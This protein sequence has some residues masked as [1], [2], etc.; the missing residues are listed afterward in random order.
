M[1]S[2]PNKLNSTLHQSA[3]SCM[4]LVMRGFLFT[5]TFLFAQFAVSE[6]LEGLAQT[7]SNQ[8]LFIVAQPSL[9]KIKCVGFTE[10]AA[11]ILKKISTDDYLIIQ[12][13]LQKNPNPA[14]SEPVFLVSNVLGVGLSDLIGGWRD[15]KQNLV[16][17]NFSQVFITETRANLSIPKENMQY[18]I[19][20]SEGGWMIFFTSQESIQIARLSIVADELELTFIEAESGNVSQSK[21]F[22]RIKP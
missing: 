6:T 22:N 20:P 19:S 10:E 14:H 9:Q 15:K 1:M 5:L 21:K 16:F 3:K 8:E 12:G 2:S 18:S 17:P 13:E 7:N 4:T 11:K